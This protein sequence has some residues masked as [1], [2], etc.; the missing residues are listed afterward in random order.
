MWEKGARW[1]PPGSS[2]SDWVGK[3][4]ITITKTKEGHGMSLGLTA[5]KQVYVPFKG[6]RSRW[7]DTESGFKRDGSLSFNA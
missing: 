5:Y 3:W 2:S 1:A 6:K 4:T 7:L